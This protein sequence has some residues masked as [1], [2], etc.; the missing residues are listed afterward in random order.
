MVVY[1]LGGKCP[2]G[3][4]PGG[5]CPGGKCPGGKCPGGK[6][7]GVMAGGK[8]PGG[9]C[10]GVMA[11]GVYVWFFFVLSPFWLCHEGSAADIPDS[12]NTLTLSMIR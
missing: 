10:P 8:C 2:G 5:K 7:P 11:G 12:F 4:Y 1:V 9:K 6:C 3:K